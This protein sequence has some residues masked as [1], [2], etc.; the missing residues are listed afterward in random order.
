M[1]REVFPEFQMSA[2]Q[3]PLRTMVRCGERS[4]CYRETD[5]EVARQPRAEP[6]QSGAG[7]V[8][9]GMARQGEI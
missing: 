5:L 1:T 2:L 8:L 9:M 7:W 4:R 6:G 3:W